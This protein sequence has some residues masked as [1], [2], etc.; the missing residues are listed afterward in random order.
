MAVGE[1]QWAKI[2]LE[3]HLPPQSPQNPEKQDK[4]R[5][6]INYSNSKS[7]FI[8]MDGYWGG[9][10]GSCFSSQDQFSHSPYNERTRKRG[11]DLQWGIWSSFHSLNLTMGTLNLIFIHKNPVLYLVT[12][13]LYDHDASSELC[14]GLNRM[15]LAQNSRSMGLFLT[16][17]LIY[18]LI[19]K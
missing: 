8:P 10:R 19:R 7:S 11:T 18:T 4:K 16:Y 15:Q 1:C 12:V 17:M 5:P 2:Q 6:S 13:L 3:K 9:C 14:H